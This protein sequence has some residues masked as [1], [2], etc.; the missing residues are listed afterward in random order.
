MFESLNDDDDDEDVKASVA[1]R[2]TWLY[3]SVERCV[4]VQWWC[5]DGGCS[6][7]EA[8][9]CRLRRQIPRWTDRPWFTRLCLVVFLPCLLLSRH[10][11]VWLECFFFWNAFFLCLCLFVC[12][13]ISQWRKKIAAGNL[14]CFFD[15]Y[16]GW[17]S[18]ILVNFH[19]AKP[20]GAVWWDLHLADALVFFCHFLF[21]CLLSLLPLI[22]FTSLLM[23]SY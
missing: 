9:T 21:A 13:Q 14:A 11:V 7:A 17:A 22:I 6:A 16:P 18:P 5:G 23:P 2:R 15:Y 4:V 12:L 8:G 3:V 10:T 20:G 19:F 1:V